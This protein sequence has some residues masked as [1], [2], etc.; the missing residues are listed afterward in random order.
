MSETTESS[1]CCKIGP[2]FELL[3]LSLS[4]HSRYTSN[5][6]RPPPSVAAAQ[7]FHLESHSGLQGTLFQN[8]SLKSAEISSCVKCCEHFRRICFTLK[9][10]KVLLALIARERS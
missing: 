10:R 7:T 1:S 2:G 5:T 6:N 9:V 3:S 8:N 4:L